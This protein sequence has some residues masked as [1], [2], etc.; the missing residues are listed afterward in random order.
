VR[1]VE[2]MVS[3][4]AQVLAELHHQYVIAF[5]PSTATGWHPLVLRTRKPGLFVR[6]RSGYT[7]K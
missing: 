2:S 5:E 7:V 6:A 4:T 1:D 3:A